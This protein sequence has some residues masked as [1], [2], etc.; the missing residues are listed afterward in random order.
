MEATGT[1]G[2]WF[3]AAKEAGLLDYALELAGKSP[4]D[5]KTLN[6]VTRD[7]LKKEPR[8][9]LGVALASLRRMAEGYGYEVGPLD[10]SEAVTLAMKAGSVLE[11][12]EDVRAE[13]QGLVD[14]VGASGGFVAAGIE[15]RLN[16]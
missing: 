5:P 11:V 14:H 9:A 10:V 15:H 1:P 16:L 3:A 12:V 13:L 7:Y 2:K 6:R 4:S 8:F